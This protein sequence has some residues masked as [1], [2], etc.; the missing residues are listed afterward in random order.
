MEERDGCLMIMRGGLVEGEIKQNHD[1]AEQNEPGDTSHLKHRGVEQYLQRDE[2]H[3]RTVL[4]WYPVH[5]E[6][7]VNT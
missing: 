1:L 3:R 4:T 6:F 5:T 7:S 2:A